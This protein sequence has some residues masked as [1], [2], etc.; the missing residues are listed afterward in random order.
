MK[1]APILLLDEATSSLDSVTEANVQEAI[2]RLRQTRTSFVVA[3]R[4]STLRNADRLLVLDR[5]K[6]VGFGKHDELLR[7]CATYRSLWDSQ[8]LKD[9]PPRPQIEPST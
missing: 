9:L 7:D 2:D 3:H 8:K 4:L 1:N 6:C 5:G